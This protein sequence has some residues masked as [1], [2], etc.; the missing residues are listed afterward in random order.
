MTFLKNTQPLD[1]YVKWVASI[2]ILL[3]IGVRGSNLSHNLDVILSFL[4]TI[5]WVYV[6]IA[7]KDRAMIMM[8]TAAAIFLFPA[9]ITICISMLN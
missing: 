7:W 9:F 5:C 2:L 8:N 3:A 6:A 4:G 1:W